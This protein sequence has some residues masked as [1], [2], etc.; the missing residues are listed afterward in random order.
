MGN[1]VVDLEI[2]IIYS[3]YSG[4]TS[5]VQCELNKLRQFQM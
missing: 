3:R 4:G 2:C 5:S 1:N